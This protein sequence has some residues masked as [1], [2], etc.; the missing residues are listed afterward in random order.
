MYNYRIQ[1]QKEKLGFFVAPSAVIAVI[2]L[3]K[4]RPEFANTNWTLCRWQWHTEPQYFDVLVEQVHSYDVISDI[5]TSRVL[6]VDG[7]EALRA[8]ARKT[9]RTLAK[10]RPSAS[11]VEVHEEVSNYENNEV[12]K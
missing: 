4:Q 2:D 6:A 11:V 5:G 7:D 1:S 9:G 12:T 3:G 10:G 8:W